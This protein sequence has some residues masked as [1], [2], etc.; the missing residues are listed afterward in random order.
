MGNEAETNYWVRNDINGDV[1]GPF[2]V[3][4]M[5][6]YL[7]T[8][9]KDKFGYYKVKSSKWNDWKPLVSVIKEKGSS[10]PAAPSA[11][12]PPKAP[13]A[14]AVPP[15]TPNVK[16][17]PSSKSPVSSVRAESGISSTGGD[18]GFWDADQ[19]SDSKIAHISSPSSAAEKPAQD[20]A[21]SDDDF[22]GDALEKGENSTFDQ[23]MELQK[24][25]ITNSR[26]YPRFK[27]DVEITFL[28]AGG[29][30][31]V[32]LTKDLSLGGM[33]FQTPVP[34][35]FF[36]ESALVSLYNRTAR[37]RFM[38]NLMPVGNS[39]GFADRSFFNYLSPKHLE[40]LH[41]W[42]KG[43]EAIPV[44]DERIVALK[45]KKT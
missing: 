20:E 11:S 25:K 16:A 23:E 28:G 27:V 6:E 33:Q 5:G 14:K 35:N 34:M 9:P 2:T 30:K 21:A 18:S 8:L 45:K 31:F 12:S 39:K 37:Q 3:A 22:F 38:A 43:G 10:S 32:T 15:A 17:K 26:Q 41:E 19:K 7:K 24:H 13:V 44:Q 40:L 29:E 4:Q 36:E 1:A 42:L